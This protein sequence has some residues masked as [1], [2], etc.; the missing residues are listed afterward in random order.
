MPTEFYVAYC[1][2]DCEEHGGGVHIIGVYDSKELAQ[3]AE[4]EHRE[5]E[6]SHGCYSYTD[7]TY[8]PLRLNQTY[9][10]YY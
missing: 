7:S 4:L 8:T 10:N 6:H 2:I 3:K 1:I 9:H 5:K